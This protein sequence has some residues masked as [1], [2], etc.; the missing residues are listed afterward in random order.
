MVEATKK[1]GF[2]QDQETRVCNTASHYRE[3]FA[4][5][6]LTK[7]QHPTQILWFFTLL[8]S[9]LTSSLTNKNWFFTVK[10]DSFIIKIGSLL[11]IEGERRRKAQKKLIC[12]YQGLQGLSNSHGAIYSTSNLRYITHQQWLFGPNVDRNLCWDFEGPL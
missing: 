4:E 1:K 8:F 5:Q 2:Y 11:K 10:I 6:E 12:R 9:P 3:K 7:K